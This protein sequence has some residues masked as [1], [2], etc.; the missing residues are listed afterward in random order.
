MYKQRLS[1]DGQPVK[2]AEKHD[3]TATKAVPAANASACG[4]CYGAEEK[5]GDC[6]NT[7]DE[8]RRA[9]CQP[10]WGLGTGNWQT[11][12]QCGTQRVHACMHHAWGNG[13][14]ACVHA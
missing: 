3:V 6:C 13:G 12:W 7:C 8:V 11:L 2:E 10:S 1:P 14:V 4:S 9:R 5:A